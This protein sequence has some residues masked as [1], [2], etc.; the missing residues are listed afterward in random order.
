M[1]QFVSNLIKRLVRPE[2]QSLSAYHV[3]PAHNMLKLDAMEN[4]YHWT[5]AMK[6]A[7]TERL[8][9]A[10]L[11]RYPDAA[12]RSLCKRLKTVM[13]VPQGSDVLLGNGS[14]EIIQSMAMALAKP[15]SRLMA[16]D[17]GFVMYR[18]IARFTNMV[19]VGVKLNADD[20]S[21]N[22]DHTLALIE[23]HR[24]ALMFIA[25][26]NNPT[27]NLFSAMDIEVIAQH[28]EGLVVIDEAYQ[29]F[30]QDT[31]MG[32][33]GLHENIVVMRTVSKLGL[34]GLRLGFLA[35]EPELIA[36]FNKVRLPYNINVLTQLS[37]EFALEHFE[38]FA[39]QAALISAERHRLQSLLGK[40]PGVKVYPSRANFILFKVPNGQAGTL[41][42]GLKRHGILVK[43]LDPVGGALEHCLRVTIGR[44]QENAQFISTLGMLMGLPGH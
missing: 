5:D 42:D 33:L 14:D 35:G 30:A 6:R 18:M 24:P 12:A 31:F 39:E 22:L 13:Q 25:Y 15:G 21:I 2:I 32:R 38:V 44:P 34:A 3:P 27:G 23:D 10:E 20:F 41:F 29:P 40:I 37:T 16:F 43:N 1:S 8:V 17:P 9:Q 4:P 11:N 28:T 7:W 19:Y 26:P 36:E